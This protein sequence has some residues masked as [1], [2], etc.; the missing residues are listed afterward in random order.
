MPDVLIF[1]D[2]GFEDYG[3]NELTEDDVNEILKRHVQITQKIMLD[4]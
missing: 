3:E 2:E 4:I 1:D